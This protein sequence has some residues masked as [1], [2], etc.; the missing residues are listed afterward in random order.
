MNEG[1]QL[2]GPAALLMEMLCGLMMIS[3]TLD[4]EEFD[5]ALSLIEEKSKSCPSPVTVQAFRDQIDL[6][7]KY[8]QYLCAEAIEASAKNKTPDSGGSS[9]FSLN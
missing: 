5:A 1:G 2:T 4:K 3:V 8:K 7:R 9:P 6:L